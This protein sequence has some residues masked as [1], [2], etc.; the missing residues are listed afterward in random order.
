MSL[1]ALVSRILHKYV[2]WDVPTGKYGFVLLSR[3]VYKA[4][5]EALDEGLLQEK[6]E[7]AGRQLRECLLFMYKRADQATL[8]NYVEDMARYSGLGSVEVWPRK[9]ETS[10]LFHHDLGRRHS[11]ILNG[12]LK[13][14]IKEITCFDPVSEITD[15]SIFF[16][17]NHI[18]TQL[19]S[20]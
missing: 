16:H 15:N 20:I 2:Q 19:G 4:L 10:L 6:V 1:N 9:S 3:D 8:M 13:S 17:L 18:D 7:K 12:V 11:L 14:A 5:T